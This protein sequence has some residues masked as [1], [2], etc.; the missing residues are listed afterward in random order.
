M[1]GWQGVY[2]EAHRPRIEKMVIDEWETSKRLPH[3]HV[4][5]LASIQS[6]EE[7]RE[8]DLP[9]WAKRDA[10]LQYLVAERAKGNSID[11]AHAGASLENQDAVVQSAKEPVQGG[12]NRQKSPQFQAGI[13]SKRK[14]DDM[15]EERSGSKRPRT[16]AW[17]HGSIGPSNPR[18]VPVPPVMKKRKRHDEAEE[19]L[20]RKRAHTEPFSN[21]PG[22]NRAARSELREKM[23]NTTRAE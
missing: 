17:V 13:T 21:A 7:Q 9:P 11:D 20:E 6:Q 23:K 19:G 18:S 3:D 10:V 14:R 4:L 2:H 8:L 12:Y 5:W 22:L 1:D 15:R 16:E